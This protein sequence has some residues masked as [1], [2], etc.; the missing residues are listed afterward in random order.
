[1]KRS[2]A[3]WAV[4]GGLLVA[5]G[6]GERVVIVSHGSPNG[7]GDGAGDAG[8]GADPATDSIPPPPGGDASAVSNPPTSTTYPAPHPHTPAILSLGGPTLAN[9]VVVPVTYDSDD[10]RTPIEAFVQSIGQSNY[11]AT[12][13][14]EY[15]VGAATVG[16]PVHLTEPAPTTIDATT[17]EKWLVSNLDGTHSEWSAPKPSTVYAV[18]LPATTALTMLDGKQACVQ[19]GAYHSEAALPG[20]GSVAYAVI[21]RC[22]SFGG[23]HGL[24]V[25]TASTSHEL[26]EAATDPFVKTKPAY[27][28]TDNDDLGWTLLLQGEVGDLCTNDTSDVD[29]SVMGLGTVTRVWSNAEARAGRDPCVPHLPGVVYFNSAPVV[30]DTL[31]FTVGGQSF[32]TKGVKLPVGEQKTIDVALFSEAPTSGAWSVMAY[33]LAS[34][35]GGTPELEL[36]LDRQQGVNGDTLHLTIRTVA[37]PSTNGV[38]TFVIRSSLGPNWHY[39][40]GVVGP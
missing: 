17:L 16:A 8:A 25:V 11:W 32:S 13:A 23:L 7:A 35:K 36:L 26:I 31:V 18:F 37:A 2:I 33:D 27:A 38:S 10:M 4:A 12:V 20:G 39:W 6:P 1:M 40:V 14:R 5:C 15:G 24:D 28:Q 34:V 19:V 22:A 3:W 29:V 30:G 21:P 9:A